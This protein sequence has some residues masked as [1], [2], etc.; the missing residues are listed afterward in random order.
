MKFNIS[1]EDAKFIVNEKKHTVTC[2]IEHTDRL[3]IAFVNENFH[4]GADCDN[5]FWSC[6]ERACLYDKLIMPNKFVGVATCGPNDKWDEHIG[7]VIAFSRAKDNLLRSFFKRAQT[8]VSCIDGWLNEAV[9]IINNLGDR[10]AENTE[11][12]HNYINDLLGP[13][14]EAENVD[15]ANS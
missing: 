7:R 6:C 14:P 5:N 9:E 12:R 3:F 8:Y 2:V 10:L 13:E 15:T 1:A 11:K 4:L